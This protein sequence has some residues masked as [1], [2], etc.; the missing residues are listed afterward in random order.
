MLNELHSSFDDLFIFISSTSKIFKYSLKNEI[1]VTKIRFFKKIKTFNYSSFIQNFNDDSRYFIEKIYFRI[2]SFFSFFFLQFRLNQIMIRHFE[3]Q[4]RDF[5]FRFFW[6]RRFYDRCR[7]LFQNSWI[8]N[9]QK[10]YARFHVQ[11]EMTINNK[12]KNKFFFS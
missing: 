10:N 8:E 11:N 9:L 12:R 2:F 4:Q 5:F 3:F 7:E 6:L 1:V